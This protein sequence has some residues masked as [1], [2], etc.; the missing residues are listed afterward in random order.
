MKLKLTEETKFLLETA[1]NGAIRYI[2]SVP[3]YKLEN[4]AAE[5]WGNACYKR[6]CDFMSKHF[7]AQIELAFA[8]CFIYSCFRRILPIWGN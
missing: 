4:P 3:N 8:A 1:N 2:F 5:M 6:Y 7:L